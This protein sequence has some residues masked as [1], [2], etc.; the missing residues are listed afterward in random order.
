ME[1]VSENALDALR[2]AIDDVNEMSRCGNST[3]EYQAL[4]YMM[5]KA[6]A[7]LSEVGY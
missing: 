5:G 3:D 2:S 1:E 6:E 4:Q 7:L